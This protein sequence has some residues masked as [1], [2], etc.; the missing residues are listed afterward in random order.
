MKQI[1]KVGKEWIKIRKAWLK[2]HPPNHE[3]YYICAICGKWI[4]TVE[5]DHIRPRSNRPDLR[6]EFDNLQPLCHR[7]NT[8]KGSKH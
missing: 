7:C 1:G 8:E 6:F 3:G 5:V 2:A 4:T